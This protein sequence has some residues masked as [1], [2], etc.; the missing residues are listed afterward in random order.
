MFPDIY[1]IETFSKNSIFEAGVDEN[2]LYRSEIQCDTN[3]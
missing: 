1:N 3:S 2:N